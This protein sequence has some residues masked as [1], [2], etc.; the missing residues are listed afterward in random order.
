MHAC[1]SVYKHCM[2]VCLYLGELLH[3]TALLLLFLLCGYSTH[4]AV[5]QRDG[6]L[7]LLV[8]HEG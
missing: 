8:V 5:R 6:V 3:A 2:C 4:G 1:L 7:L